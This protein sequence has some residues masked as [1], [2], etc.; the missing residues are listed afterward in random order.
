MALHPDDLEH[1]RLIH[2]TRTM[3]SIAIA[4]GLVTD[5]YGSMLRTAAICEG[6]LA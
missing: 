4:N 3:L 5:T 1:S 2:A 6:V